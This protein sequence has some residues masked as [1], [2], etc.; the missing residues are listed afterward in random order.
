M[1][2]ETLDCVRAVLLGGVVVACVEQIALVGIQGEEILAVLAADD[3]LAV[4]LGDVEALF[5]AARR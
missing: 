2:L 5:R 1:L 3:V 4:N